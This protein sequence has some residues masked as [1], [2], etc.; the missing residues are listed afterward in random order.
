MYNFGTRL[1]SCKGNLGDV[2]DYKKLKHFLSKF[3]DIISSGKSSF[4]F[5]L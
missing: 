3:P 4:Y 2:C 5:D 1:S